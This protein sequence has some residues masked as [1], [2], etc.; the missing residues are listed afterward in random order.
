MEKQYYCKQNYLQIGIVRIYSSTVLEL[1]RR[2]CDV[3]KLI[4]NRKSVC[5]Y[6]WQIIRMVVCSLGFQVVH[7]ANFPTTSSFI[8]FL[9]TVTHIFFSQWRWDAV[10]S[11]T[12]AY[13]LEWRRI[14]VENRVSFLILRLNFLDKYQ[15]RYI[16]SNH[17][18]FG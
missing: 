11:H 18:V 10:K 2:L 3:G 16:E 13:L 6:L 5:C 1:K 15:N 7:V 12:N 17:C 8:H 9:E 14:S 4:P